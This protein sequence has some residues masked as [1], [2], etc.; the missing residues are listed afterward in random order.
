MYW[1]LN[2]LLTNIHLNIPVASFP[3]VCLKNQ[4]FSSELVPGNEARA[5]QCSCSILTWCNDDL[6]LSLK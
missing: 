1:V 3:G 4:I 6:V 5:L 2:E